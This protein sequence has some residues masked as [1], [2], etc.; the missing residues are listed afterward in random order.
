MKIKQMG[1]FCRSWLLIFLGY[2]AIMGPLF[3]WFARDTTRRELTDF[4]GEKI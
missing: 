1:K 4:V 2:L 3:L